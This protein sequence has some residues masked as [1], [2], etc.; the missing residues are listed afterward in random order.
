MK[1]RL[2]NFINRLSWRYQCWKTQTCPKHMRSSCGGCTMCFNEEQVRL[3]KKRT[4]MLESYGKA[5]KEEE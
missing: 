1:N 3:N 4:A 2:L 5:S